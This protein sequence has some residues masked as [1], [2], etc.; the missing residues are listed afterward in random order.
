MT[1][2]PRLSF[3]GVDHV[4]SILEPYGA[5]FKSANGS[6]QRIFGISSMVLAPDFSS[7]ILL[8]DRGTVFQAE[9]TFNRSNMTLLQ[10]TW[11]SSRALHAFRANGSSLSLSLDAEGLTLLPDGELIMSTEGPPRIYKLPPWD[12]DPWHNTAEGP[13]IATLLEQQPLAKYTTMAERNKGFEAIAAGR[14][15]NVVVGLEGALPQDARA[16]RRLFEVDLRIGSIFRSAF[17][18]VDDP[19]K[20]E[21]LFLTELVALDADGLVQG[22]QFLALER[23]WN[24]SKG[25][26][27]RLY[28][29]DTAGV[30]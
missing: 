12:S 13:F 5:T 14:P 26:E 7:L 10:V 30:M 15:G 24:P 27:A 3:A 25:N 11:H 29:L 4:S 23:S 9:V 22:G 20:E 2:K 1:A 17:V 6:V 18:L 28:L 19:S 21:T 8:C 16:V